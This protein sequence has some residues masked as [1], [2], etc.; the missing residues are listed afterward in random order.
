M[1]EG[2]ASWLGRIRAQASL[3]DL[4]SP[5]LWTT[6]ATFDGVLEEK[7][8]DL[9]TLAPSSWDAVVRDLVRVTR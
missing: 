8:Q 4:Q 2:R 1:I 6:A 7:L 3:R 9:V 5:L